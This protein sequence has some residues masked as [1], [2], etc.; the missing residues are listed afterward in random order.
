VGFSSN[1]AKPD[2]LKKVVDKCKMITINDYD[3]K[4]IDPF[5]ANHPNVR[6]QCVGGD[7]PVEDYTHIKKYNLQNICRI[8]YNYVSIQWDGD[9]VPCPRAHGKQV[10]FGNLYNQTWDDIINGEKLKQF[11]LDLL[12]KKDNGLCEFCWAPN[13]ESCRYMFFKNEFGED[14]DKLRTW[15]Y[16]DWKKRIDERMGGEV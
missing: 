1:Y 14:S 2:I 11:K 15:E 16:M 13:C 12:L 10:V 4:G 8:P 7:F 3:K 6:L 5:L 9:V